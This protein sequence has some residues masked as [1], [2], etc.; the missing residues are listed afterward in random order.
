MRTPVAM[1]Q[2]SFRRPGTLSL[3]RAPL[4]FATDALETSGTCPHL[5]CGSTYLRF[6]IVSEQGPLPSLESI[7]MVFGGQKCGSNGRT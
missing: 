5:K 6:R 7:L 1:T 4:S 2:G 3:Q